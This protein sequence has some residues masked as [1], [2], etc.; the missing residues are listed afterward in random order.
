MFDFWLDVHEKDQ[1]LILSLAFY[2]ENKLHHF[3]GSF[4]VL[5]K[6][7]GWEMRASQTVKFT[8]RRL[9]LSM[10]PVL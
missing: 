3:C 1:Y 4:Q 9:P 7:T 2:Q 10:P 5:K 8:A 6:G